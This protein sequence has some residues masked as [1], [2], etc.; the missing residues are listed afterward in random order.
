MIGLRAE[1]EIDERRAAADLAALGLGDAAGHGNQHG[2]A[3]ARFAC[4]QRT[5]LAELGIDL[6]RRLFSDVASVEDDQVGTFGRGAPLK[7][8]RRQQLGHARRIVDIH[9]TTVGCYKDAL[10]HTLHPRCGDTCSG[11]FDR[12]RGRLTEIAAGAAVL[13]VGGSG[14]G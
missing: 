12:A 8:E 3:P 11:R 7:A 9:L 5:D 2:F 6:F 1:D 13:A 10:G 4:F 14:T